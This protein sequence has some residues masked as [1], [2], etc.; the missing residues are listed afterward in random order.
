MT[1]ISRESVSVQKHSVS[2]F[3]VCCQFSVPRLSNRQGIGVGVF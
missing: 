2:T 3:Q 1:M